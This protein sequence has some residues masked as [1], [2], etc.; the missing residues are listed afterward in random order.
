MNIIKYLDIC[1]CMYVY[2]EL[3]KYYARL[4]TGV[5]RCLGRPT[6]RL[7]GR[8]TDAAPKHSLC[9]FSSVSEYMVTRFDVH[10]Q[11]GNV[12]VY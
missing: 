7:P 11:S 3:P 5:V 4:Y 10:L 8:H 6:R 2:T 1:V 9:Y 12:N